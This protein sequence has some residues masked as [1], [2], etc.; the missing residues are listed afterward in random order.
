MMDILGL[1]SLDVWV[2]QMVLVNLLIAVVMITAL[3]FIT[4]LV[5]SV[6]SSQELATRDNFAFG[7][8]M[9]GGILALAL[10]LTGAL[11]GDAAPTLGEELLSVLGYG[12]LGLLL[13][14]LGRIF[15]DRLVLTGMA[16]QG[17]IRSGNLA[18]A[19]FDLSN[20]LVIGLILRAVM[21]WVEGDQLTGLL[22]VLLAFLVTQLLMA[23]VTRYRLF[24]YA[25]R[26]AGASLQEALKAGNLALA[27]RY[28]GHLVGVALGVTAAS[29]IVVYD[30]ERLLVCLGTWLGV[31]LV[32]VLLVS[33]LSILARKIV[34]MG[35]DV[36]EEV[37]HQ[38]NVGV[39]AVECAIYLS[40]GLLLAAL[41]G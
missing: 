40:M 7:I 3:R 32:L 13:I 31:S 5:A 9:S 37:D 2:Y 10:M 4:G 39:A 26:H 34:L 12:F 36:V 29:G 21:L 16:V 15:Q 14:S 18:A 11:A 38:K 24:V 25:R 1:T 33:L 27:V 23:L 30:Q 41:F 35:I 6:D 22:T 28:L 20:S 17:Q 8:S 19:V